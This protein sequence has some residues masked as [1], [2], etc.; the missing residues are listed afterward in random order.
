MKYL[1]FLISPVFMGI[2]FVV[3]AVAMAVATFLE[4]D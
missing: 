4:N 2:L 1:K 3:F